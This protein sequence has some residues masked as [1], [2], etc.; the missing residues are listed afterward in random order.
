MKN[1][2][3]E[4]ERRKAKGRMEMEKRGKRKAI[5]RKLQRITVK[6]AYGR[7]RYKIGYRKMAM[8]E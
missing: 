6:N 4:S 7:K 2:L 1:G 5:G 3:E 8:E